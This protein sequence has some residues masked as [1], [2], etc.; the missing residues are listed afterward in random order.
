MN[1]KEP[2][3]VHVA[4]GANCKLIYIITVIWYL[5]FEVFHWS[6][7]IIDKI[8]IF[9]LFNGIIREKESWENI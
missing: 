4:V 7:E 9:I 1:L 8:L 2:D 3:T 5:Y 6:L